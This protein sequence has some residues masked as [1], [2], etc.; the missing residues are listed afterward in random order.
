MHSSLDLVSR[1]PKNG[2]NGFLLRGVAYRPTIAY[3]ARLKLLAPGLDVQPALRNANVPWKLPGMLG[4][5]RGKDAA[6]DAWDRCF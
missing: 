6:A 1:H 4:S 3:P 5:P 2:I